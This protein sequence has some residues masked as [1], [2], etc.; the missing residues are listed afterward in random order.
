MDNYDVNQYN[1]KNDNEK[2]IHHRYTNY[3]CTVQLLI[4]YTAITK[5]WN[6]K[7]LSNDNYE[8]SL[9]TCNDVPLEKLLQ[10]FI[11]I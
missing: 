5:G 1:T 10:E 8:L 9:I 11:P 6:V 2:A 7:K 3:V 4:L